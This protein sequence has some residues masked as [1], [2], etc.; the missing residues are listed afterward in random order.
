MVVKFERLLGK[1]KITRP[2]DPIEIFNDLD[3]EIGKES[4]RDSQKSVLKELF[5]EEIIVYYLHIFGAAYK[6]EI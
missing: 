1:G 4:L 6:W 3:K 5:L 2:I